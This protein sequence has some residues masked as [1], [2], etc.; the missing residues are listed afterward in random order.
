MRGE[1]LRERAR[2]LLLLGFELLKHR[3]ESLRIVA[4]LV[5]VLHA[6]VVGFGLEA[7][8]ETEERQRQSQTG[9]RLDSVSNSAPD[10]DQRDAADLQDISSRH[11]PHGMAGGNV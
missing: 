1:G 5:H 10:K 8:R 4:A 11:F 9:R 3:Q 2:L 7:T 6:E